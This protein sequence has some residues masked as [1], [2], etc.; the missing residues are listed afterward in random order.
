MRRHDN[1]PALLAGFIEERRAMP[2]A[3]GSND[4]CLFAA[5]WVRRACGVDFAED[6]RGTY[7]SAL[8]A[9]RV[10]AKF[11]GILSVAEERARMASAP[12]AKV[13]RGD[14]VAF[15]MQRGHALGICLGDVSALVGRAGLI[16]PRTESAYAGWRL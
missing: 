8:G 14:L 11:G 15:S 12:L 4:C 9:S 16:F 5:D 13:Q 1:W 6:L 10:L 3:W 7:F 2:F